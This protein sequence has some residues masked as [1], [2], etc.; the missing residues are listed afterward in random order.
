MGGE[1]VAACVDDLHGFNIEVETPKTGS[2][3]TKNFGRGDI[4]FKTSSGAIGGVCNVDRFYAV[5][6]NKPC[7]FYFETSD[8]LPLAQVYTYNNVSMKYNI[9]PVEM[10]KKNMEGLGERYVLICE[11]TGAGYKIFK[12]PETFPIAVLRVSL[13][14][15]SLEL[16]A[17]DE[18]MLR[19]TVMPTDATNKSV[20]WESSDSSVATVENGKIKA[21][22]AGNTTITVATVDGNKTAACNVT[23]TFV[24]SRED[25]VAHELKIYP[26]PFTD[27]VH[28]HGTV[29][30][31]NFSTLLRVIN[32]VGAVVHT[33]I[34]TGSDEIIRLGHLPAGVYFFTLE[35]DGK[36]KTVKMVKE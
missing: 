11:L 36:K 27:A 31:K 15:T 16:M 10:E 3:K 2:N 12:N 24:T 9:T 7:E 4:I 22:K 33:Q 26:N 18:I 1:I 14:E 23:V 28:I 25:L 6:A 17:D 8:V 29:G 21:L 5:F 19:A 35:K 30:E 32:A 34:I 20:T 13:N